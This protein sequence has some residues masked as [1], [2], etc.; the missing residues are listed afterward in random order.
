MPGD[1]DGV[2]RIT[3]L[4]TKLEKQY[5]RLTGAPN[6]SIIRPLRVLR[7]SLD[8][9]INRYLFVETDQ[10]NRSS[11]ECYEWACEQLKCIRQDLTIQ[12]IQNRF[13]AHVYETHARMA[14][15]NGDLE[16]EHFSIVFLIVFFQ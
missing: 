1:I 15:E 9:V 14:L 6:P 7:L 12:G 8:N 3:G 2:G 11:S 10:R 13:A 5:L 16:G 4:S